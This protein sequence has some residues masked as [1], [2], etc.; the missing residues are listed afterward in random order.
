MQTLTEYLDKSESATR[1]LFDAI[2]SYNEPLRR[3]SLCFVS[4]TADDRNRTIEFENWAKQNKKEIA[5][6]YQAQQDYFAENFSKAA[7][8]GAVLQIAFKAI[9]RYSQNN[10]IP[11][12]WLSV[13]GKNKTAPKFCYG[14]QIR[15]IPLGLIIY[16]G[17]NQHMHFGDKPL[18]ETSNDIFNRLAAFYCEKDKSLRDSAFDLSNP[19]LV[20]FASNIISLVEWHSYEHYSKDLRKMIGVSIGQ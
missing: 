8:C 19:R 12:E 13:I 10:T 17:R 3:D 5:L 18:L 7:I 2:N 4:S 1:L 9:E 6:S 14:R 16:A 11:P 15:D 20:S